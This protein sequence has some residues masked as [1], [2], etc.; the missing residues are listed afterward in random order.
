MVI[1]RDVEFDKERAWDWEVD[2]GKKYKF[3]PVLNEKEE[4]Y[5]D[6]QEQAIPLQSLMVSYLPLSSSSNGSSS[7]DNLSSPLKRIRSLDELYE[8]TTFIDDDVPL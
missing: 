2:D 7:N 8:V 1:S 6:H 5:K 4:S 3:L